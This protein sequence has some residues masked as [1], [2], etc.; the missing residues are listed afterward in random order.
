VLRDQ[1]GIGGENLGLGNEMAMNQLLAHHSVIFS[2]E[3]KIM[4]VSS[5]P[6]V[7][8]A[9]MAYN[10]NT[11]FEKMSG[12]TE[13]IPVDEKELEIEPDPFLYTPEFVGYSQFKKLKEEYILF[14][15]TG[16][17]VPDSVFTRLIKLNPDNFEPYLWRAEHAI[18]NDNYSLA[19][20]DLQL[21]LTKVMP[22]ATRIL[23]KEKLTLYQEHIN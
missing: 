15:F 14:N 10:L 1:K 20:E 22:E 4:W 11:V 23:V 8:G 5:P 13:N 6:N 12:L 9:Y 17:P 19:I 21:A 7:L 2:P 16:N 18:S 3:E